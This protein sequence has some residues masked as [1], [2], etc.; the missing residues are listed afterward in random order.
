MSHRTLKQ[1][2]RRC[3]VPCYHGSLFPHALDDR[4]L[5]GCRRIHRRRKLMQVPHPPGS[6]LFLFGARIAMMIP[7]AADQAVRAHA[8]SSVL[9]GLCIMFL[10]LVI[11]RLIVIFRGIPAHLFDFI[12]VYGFGGCGGA[13]PRFWDHLL[14]QFHRGG[15]LRRKHV[16][17]RRVVWLALRWREKAEEEGNEKYILLIAY[18]IGLSLGVH[19][20]SLLVIFPVLMIIFFKKYDVTFS[21]F[22][23]FTVVALLAFGVV[24]PGIV[25]ELPGIDGRRLGRAE[26]RN[27]R[28][29]P[30]DH[31]RPRLLRCVRFIPETAEDAQPRLVVHRAYLSG[32]HDIYIGD[33]P[34][35][36]ESADERK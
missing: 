33:H 2:R 34:L 12:A 23:A 35:Q 17:P 29:D 20:L 8:L 10:Y 27:H 4:R 6:P 11:V 19:L 3:C 32:I 28:L 7:F 14:G 36:R 13:V 18:M 1:D 25:K 26:E 24:Y 22:A 5:L 9:S 31:H 30:V 16:L 21:N 15:S